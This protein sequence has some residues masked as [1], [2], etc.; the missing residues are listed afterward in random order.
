MHSAARF[1][2]WGAVT[3]GVLLLACVAAGLLALQPG[4][5][6]AE[7][8][9]AQRRWTA[10]P[11]GHYQLRI[12]ETYRRSYLEARCAQEVEVAGETVVAVDEDSCPM[13]PQTVTTLFEQLRNV[14]PVPCV[15]F[16]CACDLVGQAQAEYDARLGH[17]RRINIRWAT[18]A[19]WRHPDYWRAVWQLRGTPRCSPAA[20]AIDRTLVVTLTPIP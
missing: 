6:R 12:E 8:E 5:A 19:N 9:A 4:E 16:G 11:P 13:L 14:R 7:I 15:T 10:G 1:V 18:E 20:T 2:R 17:P 3:A